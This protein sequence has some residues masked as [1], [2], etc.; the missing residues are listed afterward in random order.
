[1][2]FP[3]LCSVS[4]LPSMTTGSSQFWKACCK[5]TLCFAVCLVS[6]SFF[7]ATAHAVPPGTRVLLFVGSNTLGEN[8]VPSLAKAYLETKKK[9]TNVQ[10]SREGEI[11]YVT[12]D[13]PDA[14]AVYV[15][16]HATGSGDCFKSFL[17]SYAGSHTVCDI[18]MSSRRINGDEFTAIEDKTGDR[19]DVRTTPYSLGTEH[20]IALDGLAIIVHHSNP[21]TRIS[22]KELRDIYSRTITDWKGLKEWHGAEGTLPIEPSRRRAP[23]GTLDFFIQHI[24]PDAAAMNDSKAMTSFV[25]N[26]EVAAQVAKTPGGI[27]FIG[28]SYPLAAGV[29]RLQVYDE[30]ENGAAMTPDQAVFPDP[31]AVQSGRYPFARV[32]YFY[33]ASLLSNDD[34]KPFIEFTLSSEGQQIIGGQGGL[35]SIKGT[36]LELATPRAKMDTP[37]PV[38]VVKSE[39]H[40]RKVVLR[41]HGSN[42]IGAECAVT[43]AMN[44]L[45]E[46]RNHAHSKSAI[47]DLTSELETPEGE[48]ALAHDVMC[49]IDGDGTWETI[50]IRPTGSSDAFRSLLNGWCDVGMSSRRISVAETRDLQEVCGDLSQSGAQF[51]LGLDALSIIVNPSNKLEHLTLDQVARVFLGNVPDWE[52]VGG[53]AGPIHVHARPERSGTYRSFCDTL[54]HGRSITGDAR[55]HAENSAVTTAVLADPQGIGF[56]PNFAV[57]EAR[58]LSIGHDE[59]AGFHL[60]TGPNVRSA[61]YPTTLC[62]FIYLYVPAEKPEAFTAEARINWETARQFALMSQTWRGQLIVAS[63]GFEPEIAFMDAGGTLHR[64]AGENALAYV[65]RLADLDAQLKR[66]KLHLQPALHDGEICSRLL[67]DENQT[68]L[69]H[70]SRNTLQMKLPAWLSL[71]ADGAPN[72]FAAEGWTDDLVAGDQAMEICTKRA[73]TVAT[74]IKESVGRPAKAVGKGNSNY[75]PNDS[76]ENKHM[77]RRVVIK[78][79]SK[80]P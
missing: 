15:E 20:S 26:E 28:Q 43:L 68:A 56:V 24:K 78:V 46:Q 22:F 51:A 7:L 45:L 79:A 74:M 50:E 30:S 19:F 47:E 52:K 36:R 11:V 70:E 34:I 3:P 58:T 27:G 57:G 76:E 80:S 1:M 72:G 4:I 16:V 59:N 55:R 40:P 53:V 71:Y 17:G 77:N 14:G 39:K 23:S 21:L 2:G 54:L 25:A 69:S 9:A 44:F 37:A 13:T 6:L 61:N 35:I 18:G 48:K 12:G 29:K 62:R 64:K 67:F 5:R 31:E 75:P 60:P 33:N 49:D 73:T 8:A 63:C 65:E 66:G 41:L 32:L 10:I 38:L 42:T